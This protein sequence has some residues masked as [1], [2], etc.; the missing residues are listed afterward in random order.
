MQVPPNACS[1]SE[2]R[3]FV[4]KIHPAL[5]ITS[6]KDTDLLMLT[7][8]TFPSHK[9]FKD[10]SRPC[11]PFFFEKCRELNLFPSQGKDHTHEVFDRDLIRLRI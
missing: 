7:V 10:V 6:E 3:C 1:H 8:P 4:S 11:N 9:Y 5:H 2:L